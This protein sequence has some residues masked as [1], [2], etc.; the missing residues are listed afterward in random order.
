[1]SS[2]SGGG[3]DPAAAPPPPRT[4]QTVRAA[5]V[6]SS[7]SWQTPR[8][9]CSESGAGLDPADAPPCSDRDGGDVPF[10]A[11]VGSNVARHP[12]SP[13]R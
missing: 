2:T 13:P 3:P 10:P 4:P 11:P 5:Q 6:P 9:A 12:T 8:W 7:I 1:M